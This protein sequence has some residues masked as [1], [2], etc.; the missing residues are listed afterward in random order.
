VLFFL[1]NEFYFVV[2]KGVCEYCKNKNHHRICCDDL[3]HFYEHYACHHHD[4]LRIAIVIAT[5]I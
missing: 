3:L 1:H 2:T 4:P 5:I